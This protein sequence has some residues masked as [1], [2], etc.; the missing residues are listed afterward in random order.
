VLGIW[1][2]DDTLII[3]SWLNSL[4]ITILF[5]VATRYGQGYHLENVP[6]NLFETSFSITYVTLI[7]Y[8]LAL[9]LTKLSILVFYLRVF[10]ARR[11]RLLSWGTIIFMGLAMIPILVGDILQCNPATR[12]SFFGNNIVCLEPTPVL[13]ASTVVHTV[14]DGWLI[15]MVIPIVS[16]LQIPKGQKFTLM[17]VLSL[18]VL[19]ILASIARILSIL[20][21]STQSDITWILADFDVWTMLEVATGI[22]CA[23]APALRP[24]LQKFFPGLMKS[25]MSSVSAGRTT[26]TAVERAAGRPVS[27]I[28]LQGRDLGNRDLEDGSRRGHVKKDS[29]LSDT[30]SEER[31]I[32]KGG[33]MVRKTDT[34]VTDRLYGLGGTSQRDTG[35]TGYMRD[36]ISLDEGVDVMMGR[37]P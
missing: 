32:L 8:Q 35:D 36:G 20:N 31:L 6:F 29:W 12:E 16:T 34:M 15:I 17:G 22:V 27:A 1:G 7:C 30:V 26:R 11:E 5:C 21:T 23:C 28:E 25:I 24:L 13:I 2:W 9:C 37:P 33:R 4:S 14:L 18:G 10:T 19:V 3:F